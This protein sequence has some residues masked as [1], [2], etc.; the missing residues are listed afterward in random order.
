VKEY[1]E[2]GK[3]RTLN[4]ESPF[5]ENKKYDEYIIKY[6]KEYSNDYKIDPALIKIMMKQESRFKP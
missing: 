1:K 2:N 4:Q 3:L 6:S 5:R